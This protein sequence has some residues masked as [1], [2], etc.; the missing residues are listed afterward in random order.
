MHPPPASST[1]RSGRGQ[2]RLLTVCTPLRRALR[3]APR[4][5]SD[6]ARIEL[7]S[8]SDRAQIELR[9]SSDRAQIELG[10]SSDRAQIELRP[11]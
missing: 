7:G 3:A 11:P 8:S 2:P 9:L 4:S 6:R 1:R 5:S 10:S